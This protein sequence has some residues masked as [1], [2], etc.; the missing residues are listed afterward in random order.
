MNHRVRTI[1][2]EARKLTLEERRELFD[3]LEVEF[4]G[5]TGDGSPEEVEAA[6]LAEVERRAEKADRG[7]TTFVDFDEAMARAR[8]RIR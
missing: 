2:E 4:A 3:L 8:Q 7:E 6:W 5:D 1:V